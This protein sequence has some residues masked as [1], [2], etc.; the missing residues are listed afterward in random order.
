MSNGTGAAEGPGL[1]AFTET[2]GHGNPPQD[3]A[4]RF[5]GGPLESIAFHDFSFHEYILP[6]ESGFSQNIESL[7]ETGRRYLE[8]IRQTAV[9]E[10]VFQHLASIM[11]A[12]EGGI[13]RAVFET[14]FPE[15]QQPFYFQ[16]WGGGPR[17]GPYV[18]VDEVLNRLYFDLYVGGLHDIVE[19]MARTGA[20]VDTLREAAYEAMLGSIAR[21]P[22]QTYAFDFFELL[23]LLDAR[24]GVPVFATPAPRGGGQEYPF[25]VFP[26]GSINLGLRLIYRQEWMPLALQTGDIVRTVPLGPGEK[27]KV[28]SK[29]IQRRKA[30]NT[31]D[32]STS[33]ET[34][35]ETSS[36]T[37]DSSEIVRETSDTFKW[38]QDLEVHANIGI[39][40]G[41]SH[42][43]FGGSDESKSK[44]TSARLS[45]AV[46]KSA[47]KTRRDSKVVVST[48]RE[49]SFESER[50]SEISNPNSEI[51]V[52]YIYS[53]LQQQYD[54]FTSLAE[55][56]SVV[57][58]AEPVP[59]PAAIGREW[60]IQHDWILG[61]WLKD[62]SFR[63]TLNTFLQEPEQEAPLVG[64]GTP[65]FAPRSSNPIADLAGAAYSKFATFSQTLSQ[66][67]GGQGTG[68]SVPDIYAEP[69]RNYVQ[70][71]RDE[72]ARV[73]SNSVRSAARER[74]YQHIRDNLLYYCRAKWSSEDADQ[75]LL[76]YK[77]E[78]RRVPTEWRATI[79]GLRTLQNGRIELVL[80]Q[81]QPT[82]ASAPLADLIDPTGPLGYNGNYVVFGLRPL[83]PSDL[84]FDADPAFQRLIG[85]R[86]AVTLADVL[87]ATR[88]PYV[89]WSPLQQRDILVD[90]A[91]R[92]FQAT[93]Q[94]A[95]NSNAAGFRAQLTQPTAEAV[96]D[97]VSYL[98]RLGSGPRAIVDAAGAP[99][100]VA[101]TSA[102]QNPL[103]PQDYG[104]YLW[105]KNGSRRFLV[106]SNN[107]QLGILV[108][109][110]A[111]LEP[112]KRAHRYI[113][114]LKE[115]QNYLGLTH[116][117]DRRTAH[118]AD[119][120]FFDPDIEKVVVVGRDA[121]ADGA[122]LG[123][124]VA[125]GG[126]PAPA[127]GGAG[128][129]APSPSPGGGTGGSAPP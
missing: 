77:K 122:T 42:T 93:A 126:A 92:G 72:A 118:V 83:Q 8:W 40:G 29:V 79:E 1:D 109:E 36:S 15:P 87:A 54:V 127:G 69:Q 119:P 98:P 85:N 32:T 57:F 48:E 19:L 50:S 31:L 52:T 4:I 46:R 94:A 96:A 95:W 113:D 91:L 25:E 114:V 49:D 65:G 106:D 45:E 90:P 67:G 116:K 123:T 97:I 26:A 88:A 35:S 70:H 105:R 18:T 5:A 2:L 101:G 80:G 27:M 30:T 82:G 47:A 84:T 89:G 129:A 76:R 7:S 41:S 63:Q 22:R 112:Y 120:A 10:A 108:G 33:S 111:A 86:L 59:P 117:N 64:S 81:F 39:F 55:V 66:P 124:V 61:K 121:G 14:F 17:Y 71:L 115:Y 28:S 58:V 16:S 73:N 110:G 102:L 78:G 74:L 125:V 100:R 12:I 104:E 21:N 103:S 9:P 128:A 23:A 6:T 53:R 34:S 44:N 38:S 68:L 107:L 51:A 99:L 3:S 43:N 75:R 24:L 11:A 56:H 62:E 37:K 60:V 13:R 20:G